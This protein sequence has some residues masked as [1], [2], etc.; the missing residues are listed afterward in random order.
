MM[1]Q[2]PME[3]VLPPET[4][5]IIGAIA[6]IYIIVQGILDALAKPRPLEPAA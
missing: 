3:T 5:I 2:L 6:A 1:A 4:Q